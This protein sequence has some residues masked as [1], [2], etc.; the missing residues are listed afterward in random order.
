VHTFV[1]W[2]WALDRA[3]GR[4]QIPWP[5]WLREALFHARPLWQ[6]GWG[7]L[8]QTLVYE[9]ALRYRCRSVGQRL[10]LY[11]APQIM[12][13]GVIA[14]GDDVEIAPGL[15]L[16]VGLGLN[17]PPELSIGDHVHIGPDN[18]F[19]VTRGLRIGRHVRTAPGVCI[20][21]NDMHPLDPV[22]RREQI[23][24]MAHTASAPIVIEDDVWIGLHA[25]VLKG[26]TLG[27]GAV[28]AA[29]AVVTE[30]VAPGAVVAGNPARAIEPAAPVGAASAHQPPV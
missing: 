27:R 17:H 15:S 14:I 1:R 25:I 4:V 2:T 30:S 23:G 20:F 24:T 28:V 13:N 10:R 11:G 22:R 12:G 29:G 8:A 18:I 6:H 16:L 7:W 3:R 26:V 21:D 9:P 5:A 19:S